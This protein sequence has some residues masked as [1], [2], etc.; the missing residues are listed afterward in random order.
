MS[1]HTAFTL[2]WCKVSFHFHHQRRNIFS[3]SHHISGKEIDLAIVALDT[4]RT[5]FVVVSGD[6]TVHIA[7]KAAHQTKR[8]IRGNTSRQAGKHGPASSYCHC[9]DKIAC[10]QKQK[11]PALLQAQQH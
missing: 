9:T 3:L 6:H 8:R 1:L 5:F 10:D 4:S 7:P 2:H 11:G